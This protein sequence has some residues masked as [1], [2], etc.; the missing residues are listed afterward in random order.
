MS[1]ARG[2]LESILK[3]ANNLKAEIE[4]AIKLRKSAHESAYNTPVPTI[5][6]EFRAEVE[7]HDKDIVAKQRE[8]SSLVRQAQ[9]AEQDRQKTESKPDTHKLM[10]KIKN[11]NDSAAKSVGKLLNYV[12]RMPGHTRL[13]ELQGLQTSELSKN[14]SPLERIKLLAAEAI[15]I[16]ECRRSD[17]RDIESLSRR[18]KELEIQ[19]RYYRQAKRMEPDELAEASVAL[20]QFDEAMEVL[21]KVKPEVQLNPSVN[22]DLIKLRNKPGWDATTKSFLHSIDYTKLNTTVAQAIEVAPDLEKQRFSAEENDMNQEASIDARIKRG[23][24]LVRKAKDLLETNTS[25]HTK[26]RGEISQIRGEIADMKGW[27][28]NSIRMMENL[29][30][31]SKSQIVKIWN[32]CK[33]L[34]DLYHLKE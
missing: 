1:A 6:K 27:L 7:K 16:V 31:S 29:K 17:K 20:K 8:L 19:A 12:S 9:I 22:P 11:C 32:G 18:V 2:A 14:K 33:E 26:L 28:N 15:A 21:R 10:Q 13:T 4:K 30:G 23:K 34:T 24:E 25:D 5:E 3:D